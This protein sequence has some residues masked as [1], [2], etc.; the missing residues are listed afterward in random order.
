MKT[1]SIFVALVCACL[2]PEAGTKC[3]GQ[4]LYYKSS[5]TLRSVTAIGQDDR[6]VSPTPGVTVGPFAIEKHGARVFFADGDSIYTNNVDDPTDVD[7]KILSAQNI[8]SIALDEVNDM[9][10]W[11]DGGIGHVNRASLSDPSTVEFLE[12]T[13]EFPGTA[14]GTLSI[15]VSATL[16]M[17]CW[18]VADELLCS[19]FDGDK[20]ISMASISHIRELAIDDQT[21]RAYFTDL[22][23]IFRVP[24][25][26]SRFVQVV[27]GSVVAPVTP[28]RFTVDFVNGD[29]Y[30][31]DSLKIWTADIDGSP[32][33]EVL[34]FPAINNNPQ[35]QV[36]LGAPLPAPCFMRFDTND[37]RDIDLRDFAR[38][39]NCLTAPR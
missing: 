37:D 34:L 25:D 15:A 11:T 8:T 23:H 16:G 32:A 13:D 28:V 33:L 10:Y 22:A 19:E 4:V 9:I 17:Y 14:G 18:A 3:L 29:L 35:M 21:G 26:R 1:R 36:K 12:T 30:W 39:Q 20:R 7:V 6:L 2:G 31:S 5:G 38:F 24:L 27:M